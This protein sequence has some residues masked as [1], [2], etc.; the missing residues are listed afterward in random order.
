MGINRLK[1]NQ[2]FSI[3]QCYAYLKEL[4]IQKKIRFSSCY[5]QEKV[6]KCEI[7]QFLRKIRKEINCLVRLADGKWKKIKN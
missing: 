3:Y 5:E 7:E 4:A 1:T 2:I 6:C